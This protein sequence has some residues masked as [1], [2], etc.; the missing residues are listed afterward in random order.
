MTATEII[1]QVISVFA[2]TVNILS[3]QCKTQRGIITSQFF[4]SILFATSF[5]MLGTLMGALTNG[6]GVI[7]AFVYRNRE[8]FHADH[9][10]WM[11]GFITLF[12]L[13]YVVSFTLLGTE[14]TTRNLILELLPVL[15]MSVSTVS[16]RMKNARAIRYLGLISSPAWLVSNICAFSIGAI[17]CEA[18]SLVS[19]LV[20]ILRFDLP[21]RR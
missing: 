8:R 16:F 2:M 3:Y 11:I 21:R 7:R 20:G 9:I 17:L 19:I 18:I 14:P 10:L 1:A 15:A 13:S 4:G 12:A 6:I 5:L